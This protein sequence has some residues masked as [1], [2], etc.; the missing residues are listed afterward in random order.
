MHYGRASLSLRSHWKLFLGA[1]ILLAAILRLW[2][3]GAVPAGF[4]ADEAAYGVLAISKN[5]TVF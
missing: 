4:H 1:I 3:L 5:E 2:H